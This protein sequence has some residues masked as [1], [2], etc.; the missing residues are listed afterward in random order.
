[1]PGGNNNVKV[2]LTDFVKIT[3][4]NSIETAVNF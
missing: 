2:E 1:M 3:D 4:F